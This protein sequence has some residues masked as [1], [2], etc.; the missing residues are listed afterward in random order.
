MLSLAPREATVRDIGNQKPT[1]G[2]HE[3]R[4]GKPLPAIKLHAD[5]CAWPARP[6]GLLAYKCGPVFAGL[7]TAAIVAYTGFT[8]G[9]TQWRTRFRQAGSPDLSSNITFTVSLASHRR[10]HSGCHTSSSE[11]CPQ[12]RNFICP[13]LLVAKRGRKKAYGCQMQDMNAAD[14]E[15]GKRAMDSLINYETVKLYGNEA[16][17]QAR[18]D[19]CLAGE[20]VP[21]IAP[22]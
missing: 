11:C 15:A 20:Q 19:K 2:H 21:T 22:A 3:L 5:A 10:R 13:I 17:E 12:G 14:A 1:K 4:G 6:A 18:Y 9:V 16:H 8:I 7:T